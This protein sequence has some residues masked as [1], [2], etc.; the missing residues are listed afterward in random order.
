MNVAAIN[1]VIVSFD[2][3]ASIEFLP[4]FRK[5]EHVLQCIDFAGWVSLEESED[6]SDSGVF[7]MPAGY[8]STRWGDW[9]DQAA[10]QLPII[11]SGRVEN[12][13]DFAIGDG[14]ALM[15]HIAG[16]HQDVTCGKR[17]RDTVDG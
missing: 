13:Q 10:V 3:R 11:V 16:N 15:R 6:Y 5:D 12:V 2:L 9:G 14:P 1:K 7:A 17:M 4:C 8:G